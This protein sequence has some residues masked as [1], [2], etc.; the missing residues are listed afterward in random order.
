M[1]QAP[2]V[3]QTKGTTEHT[4]ANTLLLLLSRG[5][6]TALG[7]T[8]EAT[9]SLLNPRMVLQ[10]DPVEGQRGGGLADGARV[11]LAGLHVVLQQLDHDSLGEVAGGASSARG[12]CVVEGLHVVLPKAERA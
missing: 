10:Q 2:N 8:G 11:I 1:T 6:R 7:L 9:G 4:H 12:G 5:S 3:P